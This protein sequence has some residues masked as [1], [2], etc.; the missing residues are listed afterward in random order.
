MVMHALA[1][2]LKYVSV[3]I[4]NWVT[5][6]THIYQEN[7]RANNINFVVP[8]ETN[9]TTIYKYLYRHYSFERNQRH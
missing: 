1:D 3:N 9:E 7:A 4:C 5:I 2:G 6:N 8:V